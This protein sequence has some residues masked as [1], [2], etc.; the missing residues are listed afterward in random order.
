MGFP[1]PFFDK[2]TINLP[3]RLHNNGT[4][5]QERKTLTIVATGAPTKPY[6]KS[7]TINGRKV[8]DPVIR[9]EDIVQGGTLVFEMSDK[10]E[11]WGNSVLYVKSPVLTVRS[12]FG[13]SSEQAR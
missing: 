10:V 7:L 5:I 6:I 1:S 8:V 4:Q 9:H 3:P 11:A 12:D 13:V 2:I